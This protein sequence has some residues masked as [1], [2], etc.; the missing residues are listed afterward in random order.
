MKNLIIKNLRMRRAQVMSMIISIAIS[1]MV[2]MALFMLYG[3]VQRGVALNEERGGA[4][5]MVV[6]TEAETFMTD[7]EMLFTGAPLIVYM[8]DSLVD[9]IAQIDGVTQVTGQFYGQTL[10]SSCCSTAQSATSR[11]SAKSACPCGGWVPLLPTRCR[12]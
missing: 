1:A 12:S 8:N 5:L 7:S 2:L 4:D 11:C 10:A 3:G 9:Q 6:P